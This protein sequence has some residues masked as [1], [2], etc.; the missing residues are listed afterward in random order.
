MRDS[1]KEVFKS[2]KGKNQVEANMEF[3]ARQAQVI[4]SLLPGGFRIE[5]LEQKSS[6]TVRLM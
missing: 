2:T 4:N 5:F 1:S 3:S 6:R